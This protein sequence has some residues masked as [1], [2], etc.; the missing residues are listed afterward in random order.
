MDAEEQQKWTVDYNLT[1]A[2]FKGQLTL[3]LLVLLDSTVE[4]ELLIH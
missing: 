4:E 3:E 1:S 2:L